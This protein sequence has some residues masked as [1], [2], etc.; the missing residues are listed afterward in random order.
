MIDEFV[1]PNWCPY[2]V[3]DATRRVPTIRHLIDA[4][5]AASLP[6]IYLAYEVGLR[7]L[8]FPT[9]EWIVPIGADV[10][11]HE[12]DIMQSVAI[13]EDIAP[14]QDD[15]V[16]LKH[17]YSGFHGTEL[18]L[19]LR[20]L[21]TSTVVR[22][23]LARLEREGFV[24][25]TPRLGYSVAPVT[26]RDVRTLFVLLEGEAAALALVS[27]HQQL[28][29]AVVSGDAGHARE[30]AVGQIRASQSMVIEALLANE[31]LLP[32]NV[33]ATPYTQSPLRVVDAG[34]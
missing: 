16:V 29:K 6:V 11:E 18:D 25:V 27:E 28:V 20:A 22:E 8:N 19:V 5:H 23:A 34:S 17:C 21:N 32:T 2:W 9:T 13:H 24:Q 14:Q 30:L 26:L 31:A 1:K 4:F 12:H 7:G 15:L 33:A 10:T 3:P